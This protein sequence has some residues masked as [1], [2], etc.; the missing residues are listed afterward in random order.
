MCLIATIVTCKFASSFQKQTVPSLYQALKLHQCEEYKS[1]PERSI[2]V[3]V[4][5]VLSRMGN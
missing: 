2:L 4:F 5:W 3:S 1:I